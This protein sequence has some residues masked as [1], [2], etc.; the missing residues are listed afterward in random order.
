M[1]TCSICKLQAHPH[2]DLDGMPE[3]Q[4][5][6]SAS[7]PNCSHQPHANTPKQLS[8]SAAEAMP[9]QLSTMSKH[10][11][12]QAGHDDVQMHALQPGNLPPSSTAPAV[13]AST[14]TVL[15]AADLQLCEASE[16]AKARPASAAATQPDAAAG[17]KSVKRPTGTLPR[18]RSAQPAVISPEAQHESMLQSDAAADALQAAKAAARV[19]S[20]TLK[21]PA[22]TLSRPHSSIPDGQSEAL[23]QSTA[24]R[25]PKP[26]LLRDQH[27][28][29]ESLHQKSSFP[30]D[31]FMRHEAAC[32]SPSAVQQALSTPSIFSG[33]QDEPGTEPQAT[34]R[35]SPKPTLLRGQHMPG[36]LLHQKTAFP[37]DVL[38]RHEAATQQHSFADESLQLAQQQ[39]T[40][41]QGG[42]TSHIGS[43][44]GMSTMPAASHDSPKPA[45][46]HGAASTAVV[47]PAAAVIAALP[48]QNN[49]RAC[50]AIPVSALA[51]LVSSGRSTSRLGQSIR[52]SGFPGT[53]RVA[54]EPWCEMTSHDL[55]HGKSWAKEWFALG[56]QEEEA[57]VSPDFTQLLQQQSAQPGSINQQSGH[58]ATQQPPS[59]LLHPSL[60]QS[61]QLSADLSGASQRLLE[62]TMGTLMP[63]AVAAD[64]GHEG[65]PAGDAGMTQGQD[66]IPTDDEVQ[67]RPWTAPDSLLGAAASPWVLD[68]RRLHSARPG[69]GGSP[70]AR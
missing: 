7:M 42:V 58:Q 30:A 67:T 55:A 59:Q 31:I 11:H 66:Y 25:S 1:L 20:G 23:L 41:S 48:L 44:S 63:Q 51:S 10:A 46:M 9:A 6:G 47:R 4:Q 62:G 5:T 36:E 34:S 2:A 28:P 49:S 27:L 13:P 57:S 45:A 56:S 64:T 16:R 69:S 14:T 18:P 22:R 60:P 15:A 37:P 19:A 52:S 24:R 32:T 12:G 70:T 39:A 26:T 43:I 29:G 54:A 38:T 35:R 61:A 68:V 33:M 65:T 21:R 53:P 3:V 8:G 40:L 17:A 50:E